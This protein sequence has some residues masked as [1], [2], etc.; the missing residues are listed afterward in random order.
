MISVGETMIKLL[1]AVVPK[2]T[3]LAAVK[4]LPV[5]TTLV[6]PEAAPDAGLTP[7]TTAAVTY[8]NEVEAVMLALLTVTFTVPAACG[9]A[10]AVICVSELT[11]KLAATPPKFTALTP[12]KL[13]PLMVTTLPP[14]VGPVPGLIAEILGVV[15]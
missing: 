5:M 4:L 13:L 6:P 10:V 8:V 3:A 11:V 7:E 14:A 9:G 1:A 15:I 2:S 12:V